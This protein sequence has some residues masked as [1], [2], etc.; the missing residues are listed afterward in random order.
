VRLA[1]RVGLSLGYS[2][3]DL[4]RLKEMSGGAPF[5]S[6]LEIRRVIDNYK[7]LDDWRANYRIQSVRSSLKNERITCIDAAILAYGLLEI[8][9]PETKRGVL[10]IHRRDPKKDEEVGHCVALFWTPEGKVGSFS[11]SNYKGL[12]HRDPKYADEVAIATSYGEAY[13]EMGFQP[14]YFGVTTLEEA[15]PDLDW[16]LHDG[17]LNEISD[18]LQASYA[19]GFM[20]E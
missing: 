8:L 10:A 13:V 5:D 9:F 17:P 16:R 1:V 19:Y 4:S 3:S 20:L 2:E 6:P 12:G 11:K 14:L 18:R 7:Y 15:A